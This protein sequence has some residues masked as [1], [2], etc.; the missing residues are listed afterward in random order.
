MATDNTG[1]SGV[2]GPDGN[3]I[4][5]VED[6]E[7]TSRLE[8]FVLEEEGYSVPCA[9]SGEEALEIL[10]TAAPS[11][12][13]LDIMLPDMDGFTTCQKI[14]EYSQVPIITVTAEGREE[15]KIHGLE[16]SADDYI[17]KPFSIHE[18]A[19][20]VKAV[21][22]RIKSMRSNVMPI[23]VRKPSKPDMSFLDEFDDTADE[24]GEE[25]PS[26]DG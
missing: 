8:R 16:M 6:D 25:I 26:K 20:R 19:A 1:A 18:L 12:I 9:G 15:D 17:T 23:P 21:L 24:S 5:V 22:R 10:P 13:L 2:A 7:R 4:L 11:L 14:R 3:M